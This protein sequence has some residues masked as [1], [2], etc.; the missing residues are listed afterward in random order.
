M[1]TT[2]CLLTLFLCIHFCGSSQESLEQ[3]VIDSSA[4]HS[5]KKA[6][7]LSMFLPGAGQIYNHRAM[8]KGK[9]NAWWKVPVIYAGL[10]LSINSLLTNHALQRDLKNEYTY[11]VDYGV[12]NPEFPDFAQFD[13]QGVLLLYEQHKR[14][15]DLM[16]FLT[17]AVYGLNILDA[18]VE[19]HFIDFD[20]SPDLS[21]SVRPIAHDV[22]TPGIHLSLKFK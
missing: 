4:I 10:G 21:L 9:K 7:R 14:S 22:R 8:P 1:K 18:L 5:P 2:C 11:R 13:D 3:Q 16:I 12:P 19:A 17:A 20:V 15:R 6:A